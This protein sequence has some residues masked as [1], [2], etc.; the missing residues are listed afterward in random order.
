VSGALACLA[1][2]LL[3]WPGD[4]VSLHRL[5]VAVRPRG[6]RRVPAALPSSPVAAGLA[7]AGAAALCSTPLVAVLAGVC[8]A[9]GVR[10]RGRRR[11]A[12]AAEG[13]GLALAETLAV[14]AAELRAGRSPAAAVATATSACPDERTGRELAAPRGAAT[15]GN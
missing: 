2:S 1:A 12:M 4:P 14:L 8:A 15:S 5:A 9:L 11:T 3:A 10:G 6:P 7:V 13:R